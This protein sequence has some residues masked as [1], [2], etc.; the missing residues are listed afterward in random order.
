MS[1]FWS[2]A[3]PSLKRLTK[4]LSKLR[5]FQIYFALCN[6]VQGCEHE[7]I[8]WV[9]FEWCLFAKVSATMRGKTRLI[10][11]YTFTGV[12]SFRIFPQEIASSGLNDKD[13]VVFCPVFENI[14]NLTLP[15]NQSHQTRWQ[16]WRRDWSRRRSSSGWR[17]RCGAWSGRRP[18]WSSLQFGC[19]HCFCQKR[20]MVRPVLTL[21]IANLL[22]SLK[23][24]R[25][26]T[27]KPDKYIV[28]FFA[29]LHKYDLTGT[30]IFEGVEEEHISETAISQ[31]RRNDRNI[32]PA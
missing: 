3:V 30:W 6:C 20:I 25:M 31:S 14:C 15:L 2:W 11:A 7:E 32:I 12:A 23:S 5:R 29:C 22:I 21:L 4:R 9:Y 13:W 19:R 1:L 10:S 18:G 17:C 26:S 28:K 16:C 24:P 27:T 8:L